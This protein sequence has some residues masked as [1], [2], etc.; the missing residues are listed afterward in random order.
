ML[1]IET[2]L[3]GRYLKPPYG[4]NGGERVKLVSPLN[5]VSPL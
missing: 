4:G 2:I 5:L 3:S 1:E